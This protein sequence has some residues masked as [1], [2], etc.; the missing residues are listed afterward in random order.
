M[1]KF[2]RLRAI[3]APL[4]IANVDTDAII[5][6]QFLKTVARKGLGEGLFYDFRHDD[7]GRV[8][9]DFI[10]HHKPYDQARIL[11]SG[12]NFGCGSS[13]EH[14]P[15]AMLDFGFRCVIAPS[16]A[17]IFYN[18]CFKNG[19]LPIT[20]D[21]NM[22]DVLMNHAKGRDPTL[23][24]DLEACT[25]ARDQE[26]DISFTIDP[27]RRRCLLQGLDD[28]GQTLKK[29]DKIDAFEKEHRANFPWL[30]THAS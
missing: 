12:P 26:K 10:L 19:I 20:L 24:I 22:V 18:N 25:I 16:F 21:P 6:K 4:D 5:P 8:I 9:D 3:A 1:Q 30:W 11:V 17:D 2:V 29:T 13:R 23:A 28:I 27:F 14:A 15:W 7:Q